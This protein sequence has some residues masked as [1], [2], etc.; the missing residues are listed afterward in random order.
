MI[1]DQV[2]VPVELAPGSHG[3]FDV[4]V[5]GQ[6]V[7]SRKG[8]LLAKLLSKPWPQGDEVVRA[9]RAALPRQRPE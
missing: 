8:G 7:V 9:V 3:Q 1:R 2:G 4:M 5:D 6:V